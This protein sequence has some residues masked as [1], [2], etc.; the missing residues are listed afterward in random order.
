MELNKQTSQNNYHAFLW[1]AVFLA[2]AT[3]FMDV[4]TI[5]PIMMLDAGGTSL[6]L[7]ILI[8]IMLGGG[9]IAQLFFTT[10]LNNQ[11]LK[12]G[13]LLGGINAR[14]FA[15]GGMSLLFYFS[16]LIN[17]SFIIWSIFILISL[18]SLSGAFANINYVDIFGKSI[19]Q[20][21][22]KAFFSIKQVISSILVFLSAF[23]AKDILSEYGY[24]INYATLFII[25]AILLTI[26]SFGFWKIHEIQTPNSRINGLKEFV[27]VAI[28]EIRTSKNL[29]NYLF[30][31]NTQGISIVLMPFL[32]LYA[33][34][35]F[36]A[37]SN[38]IGNF[39]LLKVI[40]IVI[41]GSII[42]YYSKRVRYKYLLYI[43]STLAILTPLF[44]L[45]LPGS[46][47]FPYIFLAGGIVFS[48]HRISVNGILLE[49]TTNENRALYTGLTGAGSI[50]PA[51]FSLL[52][53]WIITE[54]GF[55]IFFMLFMFIILLSFYFIFK[56]NCENRLKNRQ[57]I[58]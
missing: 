16:F 19:L 12:K 49:V 42:F 51:I 34:S 31:I 2:L 33:K 22:R 57:S 43:T 28:Q 32:T 23:V 10:F 1:H 41:T 29:R 44:V 3:N 26:A 5:I 15:L 48:I 8:A 56:I 45:M 38:D 30:L 50:L 25:A 18:F 13:Y 6:Q 55:T 11:S 17:D 52:G 53:G 58:S 7:G 47:L 24:P 9:N 27:H 54:F 21:K 14:V 4:D 35:T 40:G 37:G 20:E 39:L 46:T 36:D